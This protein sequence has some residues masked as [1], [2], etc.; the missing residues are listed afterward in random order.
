MANSED[1]VLALKLIE[2][3]YGNVHN[4]LEIA[5]DR[6]ITEYGEYTA[7]ME[8][9]TGNVG[10]ITVNM[11]KNYKRINTDMENNFNCERLRLKYRKLRTLL[12]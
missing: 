7:N 9:N 10:Q 1:N 6:I 12:W 5:Y 2:C 4:I 8:K 3:L 11:K